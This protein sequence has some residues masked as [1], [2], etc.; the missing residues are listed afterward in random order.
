MKLTVAIAVLVTPFAV[1]AGLGTAALTEQKLKR[2]IVGQHVLAIINRAEYEATVEYYPKDV[3]GEAAPAKI[4]STAGR[5]ITVQFE[6]IDDQ[7]TV[8]INEILFPVQKIV[9]PQGGELKRSD[10]VDVVAQKVDHSE[11]YD[12]VYASGTVLELYSGLVEN[13]HEVV[14]L[15]QMEDREEYAKPSAHFVLWEH[16]RIIHPK[17]VGGCEAQFQ[18][19]RKKTFPKPRHARLQAE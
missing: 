19:V 4:L 3:S 17:N 7:L 12:F 13:P 9:M 16:D 2:V 15:I 18:S 8:D 5:R 11:S 10:R 6:G 14:A 1:F